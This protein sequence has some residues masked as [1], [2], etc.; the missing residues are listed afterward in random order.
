MSF[1]VIILALVQE[2]IRRDK[3]GYWKTNLEVMPSVIQDLINK[4]NIRVEIEIR[5]PEIF[6]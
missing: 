6:K 3:I 4:I 1:G 2:L 5:V